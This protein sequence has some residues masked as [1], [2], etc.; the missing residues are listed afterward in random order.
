[1]CKV[2]SGPWRGLVVSALVLASS[3]ASAEPVA[4]DRVLAAL[5]RLEAMAQ[6]A[7][8]DGTVPGL[9]IAV[10][11]RDAVVHA[12][13]FGLREVGRPDPVDADTVFQIASMSK[14][15]A[16]T[17]VAAL[18]GRGTVRWDDRISELDLAFQLHDPYPSAEVTIRD[19]FAHRSGLPG[20]AGN[21]LEA[22]GFGRAEVL[23]RLRLVPPASSFRADYSYSNAG[24]TAGAVAAVRPSGLSWE[25]ASDALLFRPLGM[26]S[27]SSRHDDFLRRTKT[28][29][30][31]F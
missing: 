27:T 7:V 31:A 17:V 19:L 4:L 10:V 13:G 6:L 11:H 21:E 1:M 30:A 8:D 16:S 29:R 20:D 9:A 18:V 28:R 2:Q 24:L 14:P 23:H 26:T 3:G 22:I 25:D 12:K 5:P 15:I